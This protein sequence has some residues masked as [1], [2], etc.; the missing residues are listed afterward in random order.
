[1]ELASGILCIGC[2]I[3]GLSA[4]QLR[5]L[6][7]LP[8]RKKEKVQKRRGKYRKSVRSRRK[9][10]NFINWQTH[11]RV[12]KSRNCSSGKCFADRGIGKMEI[13]TRQEELKVLQRL[14]GNGNTL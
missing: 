12:R 9:S 6:C 13:S 4:V 10:F 7:F 8:E 1:M 3:H 11:N 5:I 14:T 2:K